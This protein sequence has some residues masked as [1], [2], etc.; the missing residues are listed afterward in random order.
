MM[1]S[2]KTTLSRSCVVSLF[3]T[4]GLMVA[5]LGASAEGEPACCDTTKT[6]AAVVEAK[7]ESPAKVVESDTMTAAETCRAEFQALREAHARNRREWWKFVFGK[8][9]HEK[10]DY[11]F[12]LGQPTR[13]ERIQGRREWLKFAFFTAD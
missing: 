6:E 7:V 9:E 10:T 12:F 13:A 2:M 11:A 4:F 5:P 3:F 1:G 8:S